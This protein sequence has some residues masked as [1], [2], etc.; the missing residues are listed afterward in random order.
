MAHDSPTDSRIPE[1][2]RKLV[3]W[4]RP[5]QSCAVALSGGVDSA[6]VALAARLA[7]GDHALAV[8]GVSPSQ[9][10][11]ERSAAQ[12]IAAQIGIRHFSIETHEIERDDYRSNDA[13]R[14]YHCKSE[15]YAQIAELRGAERFAVILSGANQDDLSDYRPGLQAAS[16]FQVRHPL[17][18]CAVDKV[19]VREL[20]RFW[21]LDVWDKPA[22]PCLSSR[23]AYGVDVSVERLRRIDAAEQL[24][25]ARGYGPL[26][27]RL[28]EGELARIELPPQQIFKMASE[29]ERTA[30]AEAFLNLGFRFVSLDMSG[31]RSG[32]LN[33]L[34]PLDV[35]S[36]ST[37]ATMDVRREPSVPSPP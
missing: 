30:I 7:L 28:H 37:Q 3:D 10:A 23:I 29:V 11:G 4:I 16:E 2:A 26:R 9:A 22:T 8:T 27:V 32:G 17:A 18:E 20:A 19:T 21:E 13:R 5:L 14:C 15:L 25:R 12:R 36:T 33:T 35:H 24:L 31:F 6:V 34:L 1:L